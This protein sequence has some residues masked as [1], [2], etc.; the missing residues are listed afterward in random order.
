MFYL[1]WFVWLLKISIDW[2]EF[3]EEFYNWLGERSWFIGKVWKNYVYI[4]WLRK[5]CVYVFENYKYLMEEE[6][7]YLNKKDI[8]RIV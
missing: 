1:V 3:K 4:V 2:K 8:G 7:I 6:I 5:V